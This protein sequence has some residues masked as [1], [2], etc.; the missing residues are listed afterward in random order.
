MDNFSLATARAVGDFAHAIEPRSLIA[1]A[2][3]LPAASY[4]FGRAPPTRSRH[5]A[6]RRCGVPA[7][8]SDSALRTHFSITSAIWSEFFSS[9]IMW[10]L[11]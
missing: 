10:P 11:P 7:A 4:S 9:I 6:A 8:F 3:A 1:R 5:R 2:A